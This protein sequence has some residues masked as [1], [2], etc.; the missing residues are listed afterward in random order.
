MKSLIAFSLIILS[1]GL[2][3]AQKKFEPVDCQ[4]IN[5]RTVSFPAANPGKKLVVMVTF[6]DKASDEAKTWVDPLYQKFVLKS[7]M[8]DAAFDA[9]LC[10]VSF[11]SAA[12]LSLIKMNAAK[13]RADT[14]EPLINSVLYTA[15]SATA[16]KKSMDVKND[17]S[18]YILVL[19]PEGVI[20]KQQSGSF[21]D[22]KMESLED[23][24]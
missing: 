6:S 7:G 5:S 16:L 2:L 24:F 3:T 22:D 12:E 11:V 9:S 20:L 13:I 17:K 23:A 10:V 14:P 18:V 4:D 21:S 15:Q 1:S 8:M 19:S